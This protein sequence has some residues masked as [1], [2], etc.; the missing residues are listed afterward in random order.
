[1][2]L[3]AVGLVISFVESGRTSYAVAWGVI[4]TGWFA[5]SMFLWRKHVRDD[6]DARAAA[7]APA[8]TKGRR[9]R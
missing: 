7:A 6:D 8:Q 9:T 4:A 1:M 5:V 3:I 2:S